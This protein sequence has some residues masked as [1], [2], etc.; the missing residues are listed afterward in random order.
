MEYIKIENG[1]VVLHE[2]AQTQPPDTIE[3]FN[4]Q[5]RPNTPVAWYNEDWSIKPLKELVHKELIELPTGFKLNADESDIVEMSEVEKYKA[6]V[7][8]IPDG[9]IVEEDYIRPITDDDRL[10]NGEIDEVEY[11]MRLQVKYERAR[12]RIY[13]RELDP[14]SARRARKMVL[15]TW[16]QQMETEYEA[17]CKTVSAAA[18]EKY[19]DIL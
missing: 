17:L 1:I 6:G 13:E 11:K 16:T 14:Q 15:G 19:P 10:A 18:Q 5:G 4:W 7:R 9:M 3:V 8:P 2:C 12:Q